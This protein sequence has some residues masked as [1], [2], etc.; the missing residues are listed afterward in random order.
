MAVEY[1]YESR[2]EGRWRLL[3][4]SDRWSRGSWK[5]INGRLDCE[6][7]AA[8]PQTREFRFPAEEGGEKCYLKIYHPSRLSGVFKD[9]FR[10][11]KAFRALKQGQALARFGF[12]VPFAVAAGEERNIRSLKKAFLLTQA[13]E[14]LPL[15]S[16]LRERFSPPL[17][18]AAL[19]KKR[20]WLRQ[21]AAEVRRLHQ[22]GFVHGDLV[23]SNILVRAEEGRATFFYMDHDRTRRYPVLLSRLLWRRNLVQLNRFVLPGISLQDRMR[24]LH[25]YLGERSWGGRERRLVRWLEKKTRGRRLECEQIEAEVSFRELMRWN[26]PFAKNC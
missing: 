17:E 12:H 22:C 15:A 5:E 13:V 8:H 18:P 25:V 11:S 19:R 20:E 24:F 26:G 14:A 4:L 1:R 2:H 23:P 9:L 7:P 3:V 16:L 21:L 10:D 6:E